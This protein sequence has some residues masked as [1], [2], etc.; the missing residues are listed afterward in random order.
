MVTFIEPFALLLLFTVPALWV[1]T[2]LS[3]T[4]IT[5]N[6][7]WRLWGSLAV[8]SGAIVALTLAMAGTQITMPAGALTVVFLIDHSDSIS[9]RQ[10]VYAEAYVQRAL[11][12][13]PEGVRTGVVVFGQHALVEQLASESQ[14]LRSLVGLPG[15]TRTD[16]GSAI[17]LAL[18]MLP[19]GGQGRLVLLSDGDENAGD[20]QQAASLAAARGV[21]LEVVPLN[22]L[23]DSSDVQLSGVDLPAAAREG[24]QLR[25]KV[26]TVAA[27][28]TS[29]RLQVRDNDKLVVDRMVQVVAGQGT[30]EVLV[31]ETQS[32]FNRYS[33]NL[34]ING[35]T[36]TQNNAVETY[37]VVS[38]QPRVLL[39][40][41][42]P[43]EA[44]NLHDALVAAHVDAETVAPDAM[45]ATLEALS[46]YDAVALVDVPLR[47]LPLQMS[48][49]LPAYV[50]D[51]GRGLAM[52]GGHESFGAG[53]YADTPI[54]QALP[55]KMD[56]RSDIQTPSASIVVVIDVSGS[57]AAYE[58]SK[59][60]VKLAAEGAA[61]IV[62]Q[63]RDDDEITVIP[64]DHVPHNV[65]GP[66]P[67]SERAK[68][69]ELLNN[70]DTH[71]G[72][73]NIYDALS[74]A[75]RYLRA[76]QKPVRHLITISDGDDTVQ[77]QGAR[78]LVQQLQ[79]EGITLT[80]IALGQGH[81][82]PFIQDI[83]RIGN[84]RFFLTENA[85]SIPSIVA[86]ETRQV[87]RPY[88]VEGDF[89]PAAITSGEGERAPGILRGLSVLPNLGGYVATT[90]RPTAQVLLQTPRDEPLLAVW[91]YGLGHSLA[92]T[93]D[94]K[95]Q[96][97]SDLVHWTDFP[98]LA[99]QMVSWLLPN[100]QTQPLTLDSQVSGDQLVLSAHAQ[101]ASGQGMTG[102]RVMGQMVAT[103]GSAQP[104]LLQE[105]TPGTYRAVVSN[106]QPGAY[107]VQVRAVQLDGK[108]VA[109]LIG[110]AVLPAGSEYRSS[111]TNTGLLDA[112]ARLTGGRINPFPAAVFEPT[113]TSAGIGYA[114][115]PWML[116]LVLLLLPLDVAIRRFI[117]GEALQ[118]HLGT[119]TAALRSTAHRL[120]QHL[121]QGRGRV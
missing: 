62:S 82:V 23:V 117:P 38:G 108:P 114:I 81:D 51:M 106:A 7:A 26:H 79:N 87:L 56:P 35:D 46:R 9:Q 16:I 72:G 30:V 85:T 105:V 43:G 24:Q 4:R 27:T 71:A 41:Q 59:P 70:I 75:A 74:E 97:G 99:A 15:G 92:W 96:W 111:G 112:L 77:Q 5:V 47:A 90:A 45:P 60:R 54:E 68:A 101:D 115:S 17:R 76:S 98:K 14:T 91:Q 58:G 57:M 21:P 19:T 25:L 89:T 55:V 36:R 110:G 22:G 119:R 66:L 113:H 103:D 63:M 1:L 73:I 2:L 39:V 83:A 28:A 107:E 49:I 78:P 88:L 84:G 50:R 118:A 53:G 69:L 95:G 18:G 32:G 116:W 3:R 42:S 20:A 34:E 40:E 100:Q 48:A 6:A 12:S 65:V 120:R 93:S 52:I 67:G 80:G 11:D 104:V 33:V 44:Q 86:N 121:R 29:A 64:F 102:L 31:P 94:L 109:A 8:R 37:S 10:Q 13:L 61:R